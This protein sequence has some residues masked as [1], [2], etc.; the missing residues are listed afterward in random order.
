MARLEIPTASGHDVM[1]FDHKLIGSDDP[2]VKKAMAAFDELVKEH[3]ML[4]ATKNPGDREATLVRSFKDV[5]E[6]TTFIPQRQGG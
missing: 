2:E 4:A 1:E 3:K 6:Q 5:Q